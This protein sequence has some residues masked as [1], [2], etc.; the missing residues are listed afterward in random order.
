MSAIWRFRDGTLDQTIF[1][2]VVLF[3]EYQLPPRFGPD[4]VVIDV[5]THIGS[6]AHAVLSRG[7][8]K[9]YC[10]EADRTNFQIAAEHLRPDIENGRVELVRGAVLRSDRNADA[11]RFDGY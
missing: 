1:N 10:V 9:V 4:D 6:F 7:C 11:L 2:D 8:G 5:G 3:N